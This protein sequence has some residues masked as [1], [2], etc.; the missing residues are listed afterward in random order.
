M[1]VMYH[2]RESR[3][4]PS[5]AAY[6]LHFQA[7]A[8]S[9]SLSVLLGQIANIVK[10]ENSGFCPIVTSIPE[11]LTP[12]T[13]RQTLGYTPEYFSGLCTFLVCEDWEVPRR[14]QLTVS[15][16]TL[17]HVIRLTW[18]GHDIQADR[19]FDDYLVST[20]IAC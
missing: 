1:V 18:T 4:L 5:I 19:R 15:V 11:A 3:A 7:D 16:H 8:S 14:L 9:L 20:L 13:L 6:R 2:Y 17:R 12:N 10:T